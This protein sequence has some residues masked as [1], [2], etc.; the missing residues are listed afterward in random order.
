M[1]Q[2]KIERWDAVMFGNSITKSPMIYIKP[3]I[4]FL[5][6]IRDNKYAVMCNITGTNTI[7]DG[8]M[9][10]GIVDKSCYVPNPRPNFFKKTGLYV[11]TLMATWNGYP[12][13]NNLGTVSF[14]GVEQPSSDTEVLKDRRK[15]R[16]LRSLASSQNST[17]GFT[18]PQM[19]GLG[20]GIAFI[21]IM[22]YLINTKKETSDV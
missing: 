11:I 1:T 14:K 16:E 3:D 2:Y 15:T 10:P 6:F 19:V 17:E 12:D 7:Y 4:T 22:L 21:L 8:K 18:G 9:I 20:A 5:Q 13:M